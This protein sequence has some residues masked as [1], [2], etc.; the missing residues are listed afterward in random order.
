[1]LLVLEG[2]VLRGG[3]FLRF[4]VLCGLGLG[5]VSNLDVL[6]GLGNF[7]MLSPGCRR[8]P[9]VV[10]FWEA[11]LALV[12]VVVIGLADCCCEVIVENRRSR[13]DHENAV[14]RKTI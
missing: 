10:A 13:L 2:Q 1:M 5:Q 4:G 12:L 11:I 7:N 8:D 6:V 14:S 9:N 3:F